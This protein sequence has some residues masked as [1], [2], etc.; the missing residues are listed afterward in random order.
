MTIR[1]PGYGPGK[2]A[3]WRTAT[4]HADGTVS[5]DAPAKSRVRKPSV[6][7]RFK[8]FHTAQ[9]TKEAAKR[10]GAHLDKEY[11]GAHFTTEAQLNRY[12]A[13]ERSQGR[14]AHWK[15]H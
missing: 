1:S 5:Y 2:K 9:I 13:N 12:Q 14:E 6:H 3:G 4:Y 11:G 7:T 8:P 10:C 15:Q